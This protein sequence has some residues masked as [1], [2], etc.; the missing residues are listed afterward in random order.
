MAKRKQNKAIDWK[1]IRSDY[2]AG[3]MTVREIARW[4]GISDTAIH[5]KAKAEEWKRK[6]KTQSPFEESK[7]Q[8]SALPPQSPV[9]VIQP[10][11]VKP[12][13]LADRARALTG[14]LM[15]ELETVTSHVGELEDMICQEEGDPRRRQALLKALSL[16]ERSKT[17]KDL[18]TTMKTLKEA[19]AP[20]GVK[21][22]RQAAAE[23][24]ASSGSKFAPRNGPRMVV[25]N[26]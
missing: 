18:S 17:L 7:A 8:R 12:E 26:S 6:E 3:V 9:E 2:E 11:S 1:G 16:G 14:R 19:D 22:Q 20:Q 10:A 23:N 5:K 21:Q 15:D 24:A 25:N 13:A 4:Y